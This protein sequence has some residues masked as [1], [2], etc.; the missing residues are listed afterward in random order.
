M[1]HGR[2]E[3]IPAWE[4]TPLAEEPAPLARDLRCIVAW[5]DAE[6]SWDCACHGSRFDRWGPP[7]ISRW[8]GWP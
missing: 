8:R 5:N 3:T 2:D 6:M 4:G 1:A 7:P